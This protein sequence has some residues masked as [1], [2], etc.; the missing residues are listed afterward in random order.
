MCTDR[1]Q[2]P[3]TKMLCKRKQIQAKVEEFMYVGTVNVEHEMYDNTG[4]NWSYQSSNKRFKE[5][6]EAIPGKHLIDLL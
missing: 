1:W 6:L 4:I 3:Q 5:I 2:Y